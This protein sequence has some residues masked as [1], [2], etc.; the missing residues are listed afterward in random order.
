MDKRSQL[1]KQSRS[2]C[3]ERLIEVKG[4]IARLHEESL[5]LK[6]RMDTAPDEIEEGRIRSRRR[7]L[8]RRLHELRSERSAL[9]E[10]LEQ[11]TAQLTISV[12]ETAR[13]GHTPATRESTSGAREENA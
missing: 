9:T 4:E 2:Y 10:E 12:A 11:A 6:A 3:L 13:D 5:V 1:L 8:N 7:F